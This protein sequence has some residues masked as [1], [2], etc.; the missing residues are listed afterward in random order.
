[1]TA[2]HTE[3]IYLNFGNQS[4]VTKT[5]TDLDFNGKLCKGKSSFAILNIRFLEMMIRIKVRVM[6]I[7]LLTVIV[8]G[9]VIVR[10][11]TVI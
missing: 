1:M 8:R 2:M 11:A 10:I 7:R 4:E 6:S 5:N 9:A 3:R